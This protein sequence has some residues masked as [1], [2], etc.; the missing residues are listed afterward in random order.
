MEWPGLWWLVLAGP[1]AGSLVGVLARRLPDGR[2]V[3]LDRSRCDSC[4]AAL[5]GAELVPLL[6]FLVLRGRCRRCGAPI[7]PFHWQVELA[8][9]AIAL[10]AAL[11]D[12]ADA[13]SD[14]ALGWTLLA[15]SLIDLRCGRLPDVLTLP[16]IPAGL[17]LAWWDAPELGTDH[18]VAAAVG[19]A[20]FRLL[21]LLYRRLR[22]RD[23][24]GG[25]DAKLLAAL[26][27]W[28]GLAALPGVLVGAA[29]LGLAYALL[30]RARGRV[31]TGAT[32]LPFG[33]CLA[34]AGWVVRLHS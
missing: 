11:W 26:G 33:P 10:L 18:A 16:L 19:F 29:G 2:P 24:L 5:N 3:A 22:G 32:A 1:F 20:S 7:A 15:L 25:G 17:L 31:V 23:G 27:A 34:L 9:T 4:G 8:A 14:A 13:W 12:P 21:S 28:V 30:L 6:S